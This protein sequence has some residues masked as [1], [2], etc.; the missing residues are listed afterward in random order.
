MIKKK[1]TCA[2]HANI[3]PL[4]H[5]NYYCHALSFP[6]LINRFQLLKSCYFVPSIVLRKYIKNNIHTVSHVQVETSCSK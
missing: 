1:N 3:Q 4:T 6:V 2:V 5:T